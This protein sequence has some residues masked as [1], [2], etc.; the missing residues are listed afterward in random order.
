MFKL[1]INSQWFRSDPCSGL[2]QDYLTLTNG[3]KLYHWTN[4]ST[5][6]VVYLPCTVFLGKEKLH[7]GFF[8]KKCLKKMLTCLHGYKH[9]TNSRAVETSSVSL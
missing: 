5:I 6:T 9:F 1:I 8:P 3:E 7:C 4:Y 2:V